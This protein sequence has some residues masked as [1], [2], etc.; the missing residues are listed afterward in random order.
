MTMEQEDRAKPVGNPVSVP[1]WVHAAVS[2]VS[3]RRGGYWLVASCIV[4]LVYCLPWPDLLGIRARFSPWYLAP[5]W[6]WAALM[7]AL[8]A[9]YVSAVRWMNR[10]D[11]WPKGA[12]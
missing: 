11:A 6:S 2:S 1:F 3:T 9:W 10:H 5:D 7:L 8:S 4:C 12:G